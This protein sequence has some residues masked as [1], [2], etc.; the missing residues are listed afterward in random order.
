MGAVV[1]DVVNK[2]TSGQL[3]ETD[4][5]RIR[6]EFPVLS[7]TVHGKPLVYLDNGATT[8]KPWQVINALSEF[9]SQG[10]GTVRRG[11]YKLSEES[12]RLHDQARR[13]DRQD[14]G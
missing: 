11:V 7:R 4:I 1:K 12:T 3:T 6:S 14:G 8:Q 13:G 10:Y 9:Y 5:T 2:M